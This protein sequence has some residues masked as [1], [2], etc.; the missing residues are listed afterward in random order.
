M[1]RCLELSRIKHVL[2]TYTTE[3]VYVN[4][5]CNYAGCQVHGFPMKSGFTG[6]G[7]P[8]EIGIQGFT[9]FINVVIYR[10]VIVLRVF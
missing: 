3:N 7:V 6:S 9:Q 8:D 5:F 1:S 4:I 10:N 2:H